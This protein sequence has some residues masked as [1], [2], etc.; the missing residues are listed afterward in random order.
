LQCA[1]GES[2][3]GCSDVEDVGACE[4]EG[5]LIEESL[6]FFTAS[7]NEARGLFDLEFNV[8]GVNLAGFVECPV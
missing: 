5:K 1:V 3:G 7:A 6:E 4:I 2:A 8:F